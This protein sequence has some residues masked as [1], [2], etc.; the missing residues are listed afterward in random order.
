MAIISNLFLMNQRLFILIPLLLFSTLTYAQNDSLL[1][2]PN[3]V[4][5]AVSNNIKEKKKFNRQGMM[6]SV[7]D[8]KDPA[9]YIYLPKTPNGTGVII[10]PGGGY[11]SLSMEFEG[12]S[13]A[14]WFT[15]RGVTA[16]VLK[17]RLPNDEL[18][19][20]KAIRPL[21]DAQQAIR[22]VRRGAAK[23]NI[24]P[25]KIG[26]IGF[27][28]GGHLAA[29]AGTHYDF[30]VGEIKDT[31]VS[32]RPDF[33]ILMYPGMYPNPNYFRLPPVK[34]LFDNVLG[35]NNPNDSLKHFFSNLLYITNKT[36]PTL[37]ILAADDYIL[38]PDGCIDFFLALQRHGVASEIHIY[39]KGGHGFA[40]KKQNRGHVEQ[41]DKEMEGWLRDRKL[42]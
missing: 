27:S 35:G 41:W 8:V 6:V 10:F 32:L 1:L 5:G 26:I 19:T 34:N 9:L 37:M 42:L 17:S 28:A 31:S 4:P 24:D 39:E 20:N 29:T 12:Q 15:E 25:N 30:P 23:W 38:R 40:L 14:K 36:P 2:Y 13:I 3:G 22:M 21:Q 7:S 11:V 33:M 18:M 16:F